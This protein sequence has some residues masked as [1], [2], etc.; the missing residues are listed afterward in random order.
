MKQ[1]MLT[2]K[3]R[4][5][6][7]GHLHFHSQDTKSSSG[8][9]STEEA[10]TSNASSLDS[11]FNRSLTSPRQS[12]SKDTPLSLNL[13]SSSQPSRSQPLTPQSIPPPSLSPPTPTLSLP[14]P[15]PPPMRPSLSPPV[16]KREPSPPPPP[17]PHIPSLKRSSPEDRDNSSVPLPKRHP[18]KFQPLNT[19]R[20][21]FLY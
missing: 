4:D 13:S 10:E 8:M 15:P 21:S 1:H 18:S 3:I 20:N 19:R 7:G 9:L 6:P 14:Q 5:M 11:S 12:P 17:P 2:H 16:I